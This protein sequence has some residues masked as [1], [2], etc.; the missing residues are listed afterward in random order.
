MCRCVAIVSPQ[1]ALLFRYSLF[2]FFLLLPL[3]LLL[4]P[5]RRFRVEACKIAKGYRASA[6]SSF[7]LKPL[8]N[9]VPSHERYRNHGSLDQF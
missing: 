9:V 3:N 2:S 4:Q 5:I 8:L 1:T 6:G 7:I